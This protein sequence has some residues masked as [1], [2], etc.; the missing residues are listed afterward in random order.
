MKRL[1][2]F[3][4]LVALVGITYHV[5]MARLG[6]GT[7]P[8]MA[9]SERQADFVKVDKSRRVL[10]LF[11]NQTL[12]ASFPISLGSAAD[13][14]PK[15]QEGDGRT[16]EGLSGLIGEMPG[17][18]ITSACTS[19]IPTI[20]TSPTPTRGVPPGGNVMIH[21]L[22]NGWGWLGLIQHLAD[23][24]DGCLA[25]TNADMEQIWALVP[26][27]TPVRIDP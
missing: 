18:P 2:A 25:V 1:L 23:W 8:P 16:P 5:V 9:T 7:P 26:D 24:T 20:T 4:M 10:S 17:R 11:R 13:A 3:L 21:G 19:H 15:R 14:G 12:F 22:P 6:G 27:G